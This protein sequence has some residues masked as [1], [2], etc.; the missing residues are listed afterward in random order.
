MLDIF[1]YAVIIL[2]LYLLQNY[3]SMKSIEKFLEFDGKSISI[4]FADNSWWVAIK[5]IC[6]VLNVNYERQF[7]N[8]KDD[9]ILN[10]LLAEQLIVAA[11]GRLR[12]MLCLPEM[13][14]YGWLFSI[15]SDSEELKKY[16][17]KCYEI[18]FNYFKGALTFRQNLLSEKSDIDVEIEELIKIRDESSESLRIKELNEQKKKI[19]KSL[20]EQDINLAKGQAS[21]SF[22]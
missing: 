11:D 3:Y 21:F 2:S 10:Q 17:R 6:E 4:L 8:L 13:Y 15:K 9:E 19:N 12:K 5:P 14:V 7:Q 22:N 20:K 1:F 16:K 18:L